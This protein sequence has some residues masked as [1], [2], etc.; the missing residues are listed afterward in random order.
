MT[1]TAASATSVEPWLS[2]LHESSARLAALTRDLSEAEL[3]QPSFAG[4]WTIAQV[5]S[6]LGSAAEISANLVERGVAG[7]T[8]TLGRA[9]V[10]PIWD[11]WNALGATQQRAEW[12]DSDARHLRLLDAL[13]AEQRAALRVPYFA[14]L[15]DLPTYMGYR[16]SEQSVHAWDV[17]VALAPEATIP[18][19]E[20]ALLWDRLDMVATRFRDGATLS[21]LAPANIVVNRTDDRHPAALLLN[22][23]LHLY[24]CEP[25]GTTVAIVAGP[26]EALV[27]LV[28]GRNRRE[29]DD[30]TVTGAV[31]L[32]DL[33]ALFPG[34]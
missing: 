5:L 11:R 26:T 30:V 2:A 7:G 9:E 32:E 31:T 8:E 16:V 3:S 25:A 17:E 20:V 4:D 10:E 29:V 23:E 27:R 28:Y 18:A 34:Y 1:T 21:R 12:I 22:S 24:P 15:L 13:D 33:R 6:H 14:G 19:P